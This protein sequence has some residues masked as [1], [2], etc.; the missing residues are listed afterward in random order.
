[1]FCGSFFVFIFTRSTLQSF[2][3]LCCQCK[4]NVKKFVAVDN[5]SFTLEQGDML[6]IVGT[7]GA[8]KST[9]LNAHHKACI[10]EGR[11]T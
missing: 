8:G 5:V 2:A 11:D 9:L 1:M 4:Y 7:N 10:F 3:L 6:G